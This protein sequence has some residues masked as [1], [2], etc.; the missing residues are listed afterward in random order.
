M[1]LNYR[2]PNY[3]LLGDASQHAGV[4]GVVIAGCHGHLSCRLATS[5][6]KSL[7]PRRP[8]HGGI[9]VKMCRAVPAHKEKAVIGTTLMKTAMSGRQAGKLHGYIRGRALAAERRRPRRLS[10]ALPG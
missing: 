4:V 10:K 9:S 2:D 7:F 5:M 1:R 8:F 6:R 3:L